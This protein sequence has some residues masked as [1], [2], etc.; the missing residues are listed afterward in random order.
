M[1]FKVGPQKTWSVLVGQLLYDTSQ[2]IHPGRQ[3]LRINQRNQVHLSIK[4]TIVMSYC[5]LQFIFLKPL[6][7]PR[8][9]VFC[10][11]RS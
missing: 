3:I 9:T 4:I 8:E 5:D 7:H 11:D 1:L 2:Y 6:Y 10:E